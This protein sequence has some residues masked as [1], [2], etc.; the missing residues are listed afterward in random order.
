[1]V[2]KISV[3]DTRPLKFKI[4]FT[5]RQDFELIISWEGIVEKILKKLGKKEIEVGWKEFDDKYLI[6]TNNSAL[7]RKVLSRNI[8]E[9]IFNHNIYSIS[10]QFDNK[11]KA[12]ELLNVIQRQVSTHDHA[13]E[14]IELHLK[15]IDS[16]ELANIIN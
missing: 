8:Q 3:S 1:M 11:T 13:K 4:N 12:M 16:L 15:I 7:A 10:I 5:G 14:L 2:I 6:Q 9:S